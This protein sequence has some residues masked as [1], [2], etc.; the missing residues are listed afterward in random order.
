MQK[1]K[2][3]LRCLLTDVYEQFDISS[4]FVLHIFREHIRKIHTVIR[5]TLLA[6]D[7][8]A[9]FNEI[10]RYKI[11]LRSIFSPFSYCF[12]YDNIQICI[13]L[14]LIY[15]ISIKMTIFVRCKLRRRFYGR[16]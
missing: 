9:I 4:S 13:C 3:R 11:S 2:L 15:F 8:K 14:H 7:K 1:Q 12:I 10:E 5:K 6:F 16:L